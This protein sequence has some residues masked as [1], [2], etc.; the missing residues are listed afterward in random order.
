LTKQP[1]RAREGL[2]CRFCRRLL[3]PPPTPKPQFQ[4]SPLD[5][6]KSL[7]DAISQSDALG[8]VPRSDQRLFHLGKEIRTSGKTLRSAGVDPSR[9]GGKCVV[10]VHSSRRRSP[11]PSSPAVATAPAAAARPLPKDD[12]D[13][14][15]V[16]VDPAPP[17]S[18]TLPPPP[19]TTLELDD[20][21]DDDDDDDE[22]KDAAEVREVKEVIELM[23]DSSDD[24][25]VVVEAAPRTKRQRT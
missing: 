13:D 10:H 23:D 16:C 25:P 21:D 15:V 14:E 3:P 6:I 4:V 5:T 8:R 19:P 20:D 11:S 17:P 7:K 24:E 22:N 9:F 1:S 12:D 18:A 2:T